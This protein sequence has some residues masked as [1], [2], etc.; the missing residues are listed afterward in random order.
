MAQFEVGGHLYESRKM[1]AMKQL[2]V[3]KRLI[4]LLNEM[5][6]MSQDPENIAILA[7]VQRNPAQILRHMA[8]IMTLLSKISDDDIDYVIDACM[9]VT[10]RQNAEGNGWVAA[11]APSPIPGS[12]GS[13]MFVDIEMPQ[14]VAIAFNVIRDNLAN[15]SFGRNSASK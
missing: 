15:F 9:S 13:P 1:P 5:T 11:W 6:I 14:M 3:G 4:P 2:H 10:Q 12:I 7:D 8:P